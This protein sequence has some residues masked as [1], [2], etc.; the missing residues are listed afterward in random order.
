MASRYR[1]ASPGID[2]GHLRRAMTG[3]LLPVAP[4]T[5]IPPSGTGAALKSDP[6]PLTGTAELTQRFPVQRSMSIV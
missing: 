5:H 1:L 3:A 2:A 4:T 6:S